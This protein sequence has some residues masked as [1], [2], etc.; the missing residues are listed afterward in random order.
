M[1]HHTMVTYLESEVQGVVVPVVGF[2][3][4][5]LALP[6]MAVVAKM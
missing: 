4:V 3:H 6:C 1:E 5:R 2:A